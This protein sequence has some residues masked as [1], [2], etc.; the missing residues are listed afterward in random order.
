MIRALAAL[1]AAIAAVAGAA[2]LQAEGELPP[3]KFILLVRSEGCAFGMLA[4]PLAEAGRAMARDAR[5]SRVIVDWPADAQR[6]LDLLGKPSAILAALEVSAARDDLAALERKAR[7]KL[8]GVCAV[9]GYAVHER[10]LMTRPR[11]SELGRPSPEPKV[12]ATMVRKSGIS[13]EEFVEEWA[14]THAGLS[15]A[16]RK[17]RGGDGHYVQNIVVSTLGAGSPVLDG[18]G[19]IEGPGSGA[20]GDAERRAR[21]ETASHAATF[22][23]MANSGMFTAREVIL[24][25]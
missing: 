11:R 24:K 25:D 3:D 1:V 12:L 5:T 23:D 9:D 4:V 18:I 6:N 7:R 17:A 13:R 16:W 8:G 19:E 2:P 15:L 10:R 22:Q 20:P 14:G 21:M